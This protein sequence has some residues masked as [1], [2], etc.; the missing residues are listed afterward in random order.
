MQEIIG[1][2]SI[3]L[4]GFATSI[5]D[6]IVGGVFLFIA[7][8]VFSFSFW[9]RARKEGFSNIKLFDLIN[10]VF[11]VGIVASILLQ[12]LYSYVFT[13]I[14]PINR[15]SLLYYPSYEIFIIISVIVIIY[16]CKRNR[17]SLFK[18]ADMMAISLAL[19][20]SI[21]A[22]G[23]TIQLI[24][25]NVLNTDQDLDVNNISQQYF[26]QIVPVNYLVISL[27]FVLIYVLLSQ[28]NKK[29]FFSSSSNY[30]FR[31]RN[32]SLP[33]SGYLF[34][35]YLFLVSSVMLILLSY[36]RNVLV[37]AWWFQLIIYSSGIF[38]SIA[39]FSTRLRKGKT[40]NRLT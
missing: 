37:W 40:H 8:F 20:Q 9:N 10:L 35:T 27:S 15:E 39:L 16:Y 26:N 33:V 6:T 4:T 34:A 17:W 19:M 18:I 13:T 1:N 5:I 3:F 32:S 31:K 23:L 24:I 25:T 12:R 36:T 7:T 21:V 2:I 30:F 22:I 28:L 38:I 29:R 14:Y 11:I